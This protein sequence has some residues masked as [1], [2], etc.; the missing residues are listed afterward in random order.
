M[1]FESKKLIKNLFIDHA[2]KYIHFSQN[3]F[4]VVPGFPVVVKLPTS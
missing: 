2:E 1:T 4:D 3:Y